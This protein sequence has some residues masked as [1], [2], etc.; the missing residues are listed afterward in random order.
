MLLLT[1]D[2]GGLSKKPKLRF[3]KTKFLLKIVEPIVNNKI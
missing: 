2:P 1:K 3:S